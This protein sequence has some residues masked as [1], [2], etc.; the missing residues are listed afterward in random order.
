VGDSSTKINI[1]YNTYVE[2]VCN[3]GT[4]GRRERKENV[5]GST[6]L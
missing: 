4:Q 3:S 1:I 2:Y 5:R 6:I